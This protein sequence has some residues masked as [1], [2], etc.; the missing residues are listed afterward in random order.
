MA[1]DA[2]L[3]DVSAMLDDPAYRDEVIAAQGCVRG[4]ATFEQAGETVVVVLDVVQPADDIPGFARKFVGHEINVVQ[5]EEWTS[6][7]HADLHV[8][9]PGRPGQLAGSIE[10]VGDGARTTETVDCDI[11]VHIPLVGGRLEK[12]IGDLLRK[13]LRAEERVARDYL[14]R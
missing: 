6:A 11:T 2:A 4:T 9:I 1:Y 14:S 13:A 8:T 12:L 7:E 3:A 5:R 10:L